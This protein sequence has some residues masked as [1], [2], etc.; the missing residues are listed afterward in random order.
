[1]SRRLSVFFIGIFLMVGCAS[2]TPRGDISADIGKI[3]EFNE[4][5]SVKVL[6]APAPDKA[7]Q[8]LPAPKPSATPRL[9]LEPQAKLQVKGRG[10]KKKQSESQTDAGKPTPVID[11]SKH[12]P[13]VEDGEGF[14]GRRPNNDPFWLGEKTT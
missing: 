10:K 1:M 5:V 2:R 3:K 7:A 4:M 13:E 12:L 14:T 9:G 11:A 6:P 8:S